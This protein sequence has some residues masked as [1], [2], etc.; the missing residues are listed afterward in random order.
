MCSQHMRGTVM[1]IHF[2]KAILILG[3][4]YQAMWL[5]FGGLYNSRR[6]L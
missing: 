2:P 5:L 1:K 4:Y 3:P 6:H